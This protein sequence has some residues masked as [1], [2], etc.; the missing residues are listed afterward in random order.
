[1][2]TIGFLGLGEM[3]SRMATRL[4]E[5]GHD[6]IVWNRSKEPV[7]ELVAI[8]AKEAPEAADA[9]AAEL[10]FSMLANDAA[11][12]AV[13]ASDH[14]TAGT[15]HVNMASISPAFANELTARFAAAGVGYA[16]AAVLGRPHVAAAGQLNILSAGPEPILTAAQPY[17][18]LLG[19]KT[20][21]FGETPSTA[22]SI[23]AICNYALIQAH[24]ALGESV[25]MAER[26]D[27]DPGLI[28][29][30]LTSSFFA[31]APAYTVYGP[32]IATQSYEPA[33]FTMTL[34][35]KDLGLAEQV[36][37]AT[38]TRLATMPALKEVYARAIEE[39]FADYDW[40]AIAEVTRRNLL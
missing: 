23:K 17:F 38:N 16:A 34:G 26:L 21:Y 24:Q 32:I 15:T 11:V 3:G 6:V 20:W 2:T 28:V 10:S 27:V 37:A 25:A 29:E 18:D 12:D 30:L 19:K 40:S 1:M 31:G 4:I 9:L 14:L 22:N 39:G 36:A 35:L 33:A 7:A 5:G 8:G 13:L